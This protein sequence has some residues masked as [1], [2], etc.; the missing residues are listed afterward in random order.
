MQSQY[1]RLKLACYSSA[2]SMAVV[3]TMSPL[4]FSTFITMYDISY[5]LIG[6]LV[7]INF[8]TQL[9]V[10]LVFSLFSHKF[11]LPLTVKLTP[12]IC[13]VGLF[14]YALTPALFPDNIYAGICLGTIIFSAASGLGEVLTSPVIA[15]IPSDDPDREMSKLHSMYAW[16]VVE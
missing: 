16:G 11:N 13:F 14:V 9:L 7:L 8:V 3:T 15:S 1:K 5:S 6:L 12:V 10:D 2:M 4:L